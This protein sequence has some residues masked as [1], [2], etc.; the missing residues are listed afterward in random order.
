MG[1]SLDQVILLLA[2]D[3]DDDYFITVDA[4]KEIGLDQC[5]RRVKDGEDLMNYLLHNP[6]YENPES[7]PLPDLIFLDLNMPK[8]DGREALK[9][10]KA[11]ESLKKIPIIIFTTSNS[12]DD[13]ASTYKY[14][15]NSYIQKPDSFDQFISLFQTIQNYWLDKVKL[16]T[17]KP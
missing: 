16:P 2:E 11:N 14:G 5:V 7:S 4:L 17:V 9:E 3:D 13:I 10:I 12:P 15:A 1:N 6:P 8:K